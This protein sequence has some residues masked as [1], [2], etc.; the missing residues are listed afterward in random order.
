MAMLLL[1]DLELGD[2]RSQ[3]RI[4]ADGV[5]RDE[6]QQLKSLLPKAAARARAI[7]A[8]WDFMGPARV[9][10]QLL[11][12]HNAFPRAKYLQGKTRLQRV[13]V[14]RLALDYFQ[15][16]DPLP[17]SVISLYPD[18]LRRLAKFLGEGV[19]ESYDEEYFAKDVRYA[20]GLTVPAGALQFDLKYSIGPKL[21][22]RDVRDRGSP[23]SAFAYIRSGGWGRWYNEHVDLRAMREFNPEGWTAHCAKM[24]EVLE[25]NPSVLGIV[26]VGW[27]YD[28]AVV[29]AENSPAL[30]YIQNT[31]V[32]YGAFHVRIGTE[33]HHIQNAIYRS[34]LRKRLYEEGKYLP[35]CYMLAWP[36]AALIAW[37]QRL[38]VDPSV[39]FERSEP[40][41]STARLAPSKA[42]ATHASR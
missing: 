24:A 11:N 27:F 1:R 14:A 13:A 10:G 35:T 22:L 34:A 4:A 41:P 31:Q 8:H 18:F 23:K 17:A 32:K 29:V 26:G 5:V 9:I 19:G 25:L 16:E 28:P 15:V 12:D 30:D 39:A 7:A 3:L 37:A 36:R 38:K 6:D 21:I 20:L 33:P 40:P 2:V 42:Q